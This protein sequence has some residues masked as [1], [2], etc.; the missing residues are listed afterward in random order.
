MGKQNFEDVIDQICQRDLRYCRD[1]YIF[2]RE[3]LDHTIKILKKQNGT[4]SRR[5]V[6]GQELL[7]GLRD[8][9]LKEFGPMTKTVLNTWGISTCEDFGEI[10]F[11]LVDSGILGK[12]E[13]DS[14][15]DFKNGFSFEEAFVQPFRP[16]DSP[17]MTSA[18]SPKKR[19]S[20]STNKRKKTSKKESAK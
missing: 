11:N 10:V 12:T 1:T 9:A 2:V 20:D 13:N 15:N 18:N 17:Y 3:G 7:H 4:Q 5:H 14:R 8:F 6:T 19:A 16:K